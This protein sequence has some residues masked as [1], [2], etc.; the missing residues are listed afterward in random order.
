[1][2]IPNP[3]RGLKNPK[4]VLAWGMYD[5]ANQ[6]FT[7]LIN[8]LLFAVYF[9]E[10]VVGSETEGA[11]A[12]GDRLWS[13]VVAASMLTVVVLAPFLGAL[14]DGRGA[15]KR[16]L[17]GTGVACVAFTCSFALIGSGDVVL[18]LALYFCG[19]V[20]YQFG[21]NFLASFLPEVATSRNM[22][23]VSAIGWTMGYVGALLLLL[24]MVIAIKL[25]GLDTTAEWPPLFIFAGVWFLMGM[26][27]P[28][29]VLRERPPAAEEE[30][31]ENALREAL[32]RLRSTLRSAARYRQLLRFLAAFLL[33]GMGVQTVVFFAAII[34]TDTVW[35]D[36]APEARNA[37]L[38][39]LALLLTVTAGAAAITTSFFQDR[40]GT[41]TTI[42]IYLGIWIF[43]SIALAW[44]HFET[45][46]QR[47][48][49]WH[50]WII[51]AIIGFGLG[52][53]GTA[54]R[55]MVGRF[56][57]RHK[58]AEFFGLWGTVYKLSAVVGVFT[59]GQVKAFSNTA[60][61]LVLISFFILGAVALFSVHELRGVRA[62]HRAE[63]EAG[64]RR[65]GFGK[66][67]AERARGG[68]DGSIDA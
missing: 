50:F 7:L 18:A 68:V 35:I 45:Q 32:R 46:R 63:R 8:T 66:A 51:G 5:L 2:Q 26:I 57:P 67:A 28:A 60:S 21:E 48:I 49:E 36:L 29:L 64:L 42:F 23:R 39:Y 55:A 37:R 6:S 43:G 56:T 22:G 31:A 30:R 47:A 4:E 20:A 16:M 33:Y 61:L 14:A 10:V 34:G 24:A 40:I 17:L 12:R 25:F 11:S 1:V 3:L 9:K 38:V 19:N 62:A 53:I 13:G 41:R 27:A 15:K 54:S 59:F 65:D 52:G 58:T 44:F